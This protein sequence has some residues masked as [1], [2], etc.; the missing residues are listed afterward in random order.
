[1]NHPR[2][3]R[4]ISHVR[5]GHSGS[6]GGGGRQL[7][8]G[9]AADDSERA[10]SFSEE[11]PERDELRKDGDEGDDQLERATPATVNVGATPGARS[12][13][14]SLGT[15]LARRGS[16]GN[17]H[18]VQLGNG[19]PRQRKQA[20]HARHHGDAPDKAANLLSR[21]GSESCQ[22]VFWSAPA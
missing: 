5:G 12:V 20:R 16:R 10:E 8:G 19:G 9:G 15:W 17:L 1:M 13:I 14:E 6:D 22:H 18:P 11:E 2:R 7:E 4:L 3:Q 21:R